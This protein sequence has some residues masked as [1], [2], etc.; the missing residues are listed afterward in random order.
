MYNVQASISRKKDFLVY[1]S[2]RNTLIDGTHQMV[3]NVR[4]DLGERNDLAGERQDVARRLRALLR[5]W[6]EDV[7][8]EAL[9]V[10]QE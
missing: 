8:A 6:E 9:V 5:D 4:R 1:R 10:G 2:C 3:F 7:D